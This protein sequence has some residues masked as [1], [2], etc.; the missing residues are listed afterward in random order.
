MIHELK[1]LPHYFEEVLVGSKTFEVRLNDRNFQ[2]GDVVI[3]N[4]FDAE[5]QSYSGRKLTFKIG[6]VLKDFAGL[7][8]GWVV[9]SLVGGNM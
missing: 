9:F 5:T 8:E 7:A 2:T 6:Y 4:E 3:L 1:I